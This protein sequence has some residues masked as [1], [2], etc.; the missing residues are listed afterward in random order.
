MER[1]VVRLEN[2]VPEVFPKGQV[3]ER[4]R[5]SMT[6]KGAQPLVLSNIAGPSL[7]KQAKLLHPNRK[8]GLGVPPPPPSASMASPY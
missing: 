1:V 8:G 3:G 5:R 7:E 4:V 2:F 6:V